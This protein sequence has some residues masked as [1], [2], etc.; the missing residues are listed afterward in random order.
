MA[1]KLSDLIKQ[2]SKTDPQFLARL[3]QA[4]SAGLKADK[5]AI[6]AIFI[7]ENEKFTYEA[8]DTIL[9]R[10]ENSRIDINWNVKDYIYR[11]VVSRRKKQEPKEK[12]KKG[13]N[14]TNGENNRVQTEGEDTSGQ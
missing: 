5:L 14:E 12:K 1:E 9:S 6:Y 2:L 11:L 7:K 8:F 10:H 13:G 3:E 4:A